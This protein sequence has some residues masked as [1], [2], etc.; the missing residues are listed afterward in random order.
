V[1]RA[2]RVHEHIDRAELRP[3]GAFRAN[4]RRGIGRVNRDELD[5]G[6]GYPFADVI[7]RAKPSLLV[8][9][10]HHDSGSAIR[11]LG[12]GLEPDSG[13]AAEDGNSAIG[14]FHDAYGLGSPAPTITT[15]WCPAAVS[16]SITQ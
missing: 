4:R 1:A 6:A 10:E 11:E 12:C 7:A 3:G 5:A 2:G 9:P 8:P 14:K 16:C 15:S 13:G